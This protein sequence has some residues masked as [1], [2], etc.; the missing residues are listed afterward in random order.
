[1]QQLF[2]FHSNKLSSVRLGIIMCWIKYIQISAIDISHPKSLPPVGKSDHNVILMSA[3]TKLEPS[4]AEYRFTVNRSN[5]RNSKILLA[6]A[7]R[8]YNWTTLFRMNSCTEMLECFYSVTNNLLNKFLPLRQTKK[9]STDKPWITESFRLLIRRRQYAWQHKQIEE[10]KKYR[11]KVQRAAKSLKEKYYRSRVQSLRHC[12]PR[13]WWNGVKQFT[14][15][16]DRPAL[17][18]LVENVYNGDSGR[19]ANEINN[20]LQSV[21]SDL[22]PLNSNLIP[23]ASDDCPTEYII[24]PYEVERKLSQVGAHKIQRSR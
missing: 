5:D 12:D 10:F 23:P 6:H 9:N 22:Q 18:G 8:D 1:M 17:G 20:Y 13:K 19:M 3:N 14:G 15:Q 16:S 4:N 11:N 7:L 21:S 2:H 24:E